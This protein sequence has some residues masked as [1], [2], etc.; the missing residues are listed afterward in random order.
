V[1][2]EVLT[3]TKDWLV[4]P[5]HL[6]LILRLVV[7]AAVVIMLGLLVALV[8]VVEQLLLGQTQLKTEILLRPLHHK[9]IM[10]AQPFQTQRLRSVLVVVVVELVL[11]AL[12]LFKT[13]QE[14]VVLVL[15]LR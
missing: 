12:T 9:E 11:L 14:M 7:A 5:V 15:Q 1:L 8:A 2:V 3:T 10:V 13:K 6:E 4:L